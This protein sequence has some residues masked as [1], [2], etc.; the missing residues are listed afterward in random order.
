MRPPENM[1]SDSK[2]STASYCHNDREDIDEDACLHRIRNSIQ[3]ISELEIERRR[4]VHLFSITNHVIAENQSSLPPP[5]FRLADL[6][7]TVPGNL[8]ATMPLQVPLQEA[9]KKIWTNNPCACTANNRV[10][11]VEV[12][13]QHC[14]HRCVRFL[15]SVSQ[16]AMKC[17]R[18]PVM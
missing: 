15:C 10:R 3:V 6:V 12:I 9:T 4:L 18:R 7:S 5:Q 8:L 2:S 13:F 11:P 14:F 16:I 1:K 17:S